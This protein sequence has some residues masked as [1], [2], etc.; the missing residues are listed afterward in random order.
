MIGLR[1]PSASDPRQF[2]FDCQL[3]PIRDRP[4]ITWLVVYLKSVAGLLIDR[5]RSLRIMRRRSGPQDR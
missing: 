5:T 3:G 2:V 1:T 4:L